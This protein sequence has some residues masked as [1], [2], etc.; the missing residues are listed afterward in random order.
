MAVFRVEKNTNYTTMC[1]YHLRDKRLSLKAKGLL[2]LFL[3]L[4]EEWHYSVRGIA[5]ISKEGPDSI[6]NTLRELEKSGYLLRSQKRKD[7]GRMGE[8][9][10][11]IFEFPQS[12]PSNSDLSDTNLPFPENPDT[13]KPHSDNPAEIKKY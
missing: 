4:P 6:N 11:I 5:A 7:N 9:E 12:E 8:T 13:V 2:S 1:N 3:S 10:Y